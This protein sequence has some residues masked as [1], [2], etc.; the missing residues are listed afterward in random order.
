MQKTSKNNL[1]P[2]FGIISERTG[3]ERALDGITILVAVT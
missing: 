2:F 1:P 3:A